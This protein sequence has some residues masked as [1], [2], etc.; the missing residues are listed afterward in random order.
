MQRQVIDTRLHL[1]P[2][3]LKSDQ[4]GEKPAVKELEPVLENGIGPLWLDIKA[5]WGKRCCEPLSNCG[6]QLPSR[7]QSSPSMCR[8]CCD[9]LNVTQPHP[10]AAIFRPI[11]PFFSLLWALVT[12]WLPEIPT[13]SKSASNSGRWTGVYM[14]CLLQTKIKC[15]E[16]NWMSLRS[17]G[18]LFTVQVG[19]TWPPEHVNAFFTLPECSFNFDYWSYGLGG[20]VFLD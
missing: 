7:C 1:C 14:H 8:W 4:G 2:Q 20:I 9:P 12:V 19:I 18:K 16:E 15:S 10:Q 6:L 11:L 17:A 13:E 5:Y 3:S